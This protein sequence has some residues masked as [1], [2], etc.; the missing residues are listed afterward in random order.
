MHDAGISG[1]TAARG[2]SAAPARPP[3]R[4]DAKASWYLPVAV[5]GDA[6]GA[7]VPVL[8]VYLISGQSRPL[9]AALTATVCWLAVRA[10][11]GRYVR[12]RVGETRGLLGTAH[13]WAI[14]VGCLAVLRVLTGESSAVL[15]AL[16][17]LAPTLAV[18]GLVGAAL[19]AHLTAQRRQAHAVRRVL[20]VGEARPADEV[21]AQLA[22]GTDHPFVVIGAVP[23]GDGRLTGGIPESARL[24]A[25]PSVAEGQDGALVL[26]AA[27]RHDADLVLVVPGTRLTGERLRRICW[28]LQDAGLPVTVASGLSE[29]ALGRL[30]VASVAGLNLLHVAPPTRGGAQLL[31]KGALDRAGAALGLLLL[32]PLLVLIALAVR[33]DSPGPVI[34]RQRRIG[35]HGVPFTMWKFRTMVADADRLRPQL[36]QANEHQGGPLFKLRDDPRVTRVGRL[37]RR[38][39]LD[40][41]PQLVNV[42]TGRMSLVGPRPPLPRE[43]AQYSPTEWRRLQVKPGLTGPWQVSGRSEL[44]WDEGVA[45]DLSYADNW[46]L[47]HDLD[48][49]GRTFRAVLDGRGAY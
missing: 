22:V 3:R 29:V 40:E 49:L 18:T 15:V 2:R 19:H 46:S 26:D 20:L 48:V 8:T 38:S 6:L 12:R 35:R 33:L 42:L 11:H 25:E 23:V 47:T 36:D 1:H 14:L 10:A 43:V 31:V 27:R 34:F 37:L 30:D 4:T 5:T 45:L 41:L 21:A 17:A 44:S 39:S 32:S 28:A 9:S 13:D 24:T 7:A 16:T